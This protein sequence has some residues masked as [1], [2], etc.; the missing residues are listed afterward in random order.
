MRQLSTATVAA[1]VALVFASAAHAALLPS[2]Q[3]T[4]TLRNSTPAAPSSSASAA[5][6]TTTARP[7][8]NV[9]SVD[10]RDQQTRAATAVTH[11]TGSTS[12]VAGIVGSASVNP[13]T[14]T[15]TGTGTT[16]G[17]GAGTTSGLGATG[18]SGTIT[19]GATVGLPANAAY[20]PSILVGSSSDVTT[21]TAV[22]YT[23]GNTAAYSTYAAS[24]VLGG[25]SVLDSSFA[26]DQAARA[27]GAR[28]DRAI[29]QVSRDRKR[30]G[31]NGQLLYT[32]APRT[33]VDRSHEMRDD[34][35]PPSLTGSNST[36][37]R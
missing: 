6:P 23:S 26:T 29:N 33:N 3:G 35:L 25:A 18:T 37:V 15:T 34:P 31:R 14:G 4:P 10:V 13:V 21:G 24:D 27:N 1:A 20:A 36:I 17:F 22:P 11:A 9:T 30:V 5:T 2:L 28:V 32:I 7:I 19:T 8:Q 12:S 16:S